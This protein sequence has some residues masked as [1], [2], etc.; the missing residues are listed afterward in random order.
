MTQ[1]FYCFNTYFTY[2]SNEFMDCVYES[3]KYQYIGMTLHGRERKIKR[4]E[5]AEMKFCELKVTY[6]ELK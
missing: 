2:L 1:Y 5:F 3:F 4:D 6:I